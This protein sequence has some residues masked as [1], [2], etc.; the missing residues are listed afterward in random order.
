MSFPRGAG[1][2]SVSGEEL[3]S[4]V[5]ALG[6]GLIAYGLGPGDPVA[7]IS[8]DDSEV[9]TGELAIL[10]GGGCCVPI[11]PTARPAACRTGW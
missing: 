2:V 5:S 10:A 1:R 6:A 11:D 7:V 3:E 8:G 9:W 4:E